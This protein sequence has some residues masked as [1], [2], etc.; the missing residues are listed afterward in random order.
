MEVH[1]SVARSCGGRRTG[2]ERSVMNCRLRLGVTR[3]Y[4]TGQ[5]HSRLLRGGGEGRKRAKCMD[6]LCLGPPPCCQSNKETEAF[7]DTK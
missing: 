3:L 1:V 6:V 2:S 4:M 7:R 5:I